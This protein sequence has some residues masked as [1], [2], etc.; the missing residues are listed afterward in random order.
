MAATETQIQDL[1]AQ[2]ETLLGQ[3]VP[4]REKAA[5]MEAELAAAQRD[6]ERLVGAANAETDLLRARKASLQA[7]LAAKT[8]PPPPPPPPPPNLP[9]VVPVVTPGMAPP[10]PPPEDPRAARKGALADHIFYFLDDDQEDVLQVLHAIQDNARYDVGDMLELLPWGDIWQ[11]RAGWETLD[12]QQRRLLSWL[13]ALETRLDYWQRTLPQLEGD[14]RQGLLLEKKARNPEEWQ[15]YLTGLA[16]DQEKDNAHLRQEV[17][18]LEIEW[19]KKQ[20]QGG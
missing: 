5:T 6:Y 17:Q 16:R 1:L 3:I 8:P 15:D 20:A 7:A 11:A 12:D 2:I 13:A 18:V 10:P 19:Q 9:P 4:L 14:S